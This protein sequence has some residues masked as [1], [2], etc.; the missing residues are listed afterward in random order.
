MAVVKHY[1]VTDPRAPMSL[2]QARSEATTRAKTYAATMLRERGLK[3][4]FKDA[5]DVV[6]AEDPALRSRFF[7]NPAGRFEDPRQ[8]VS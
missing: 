3:I 4:A 5:L 8:A 6:L 1:D 2:S 7:G